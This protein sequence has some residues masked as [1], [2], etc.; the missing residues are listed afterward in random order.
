MAEFDV[1]GVGVPNGR[2]FGMPYESDE[3]PVALISVPWDA[4][5]SYAAGTSRGPE[6]MIDASIQVDLFDEKIEGAQRLKIGTDESLVEL[7]NGTSVRTSEYIET[8]NSEARA[9]AKKIIDILASGKKL[10]PSACRKQDQV[11]R[12]SREINRLVEEIC[13]GYYEKGIIPGVVGG[14]H[15]VAFGAVMAAARHLEKGE[16]LGLVQFDAHADLRVAYEGFDYSHASVMYNCISKIPGI[17]TLCQIGIRDFCAD[18]NELIGAD[19]RIRAF[20][21]S[22]IS[23]DLFNGKNWNTLCN[24]IVSSLP[25]KIYISFDIDGLEPSMCPHTGTPVPG[26]ITFDMAVYLL[27]KFAQERKIVGFDL[28][29]VAPG[30]DEWDANV[31]ARLLHKLCLCATKDK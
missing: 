4:T 13:S 31:G 20:T 15:S 5:V 14:E 27:R 3:C 18:E 21:G 11:N 1:N 22:K 2:Y 30:E 19:K 12:M 29:E 8:M 28:C 17:E 16:R 25:E 10:P 24:E 23:E 7:G 6:A 9:S 26:G